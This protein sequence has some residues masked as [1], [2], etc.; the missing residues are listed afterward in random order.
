MATLTIIV[1]M[2][3]VSGVDEESVQQFFEDCA[4]DLDKDHIKEWNGGIEVT[5][6]LVE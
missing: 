6:N 5:S 3:G 1:K 4:E 2:E